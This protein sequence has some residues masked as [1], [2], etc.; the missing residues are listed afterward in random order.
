MCSGPSDPR[1]SDPRFN[2]A[3]AIFPNNDTK[4]HINKLRA[5]LFAAQ[6]KK[7]VTYAVARDKATNDTLK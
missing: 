1:W 3:T 7:I 2:T 4:Y 6:E 5:K